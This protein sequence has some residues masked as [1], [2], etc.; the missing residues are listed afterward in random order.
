MKN[1]KFIFWTIINAMI[2]GI[3]V[4]YM[5]NGLYGTQLFNVIG[6]VL[7]ASVTTNMIFLYKDKIK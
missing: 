6:V 5:F 1:K 7:F 4:Y 3:Y 2:L